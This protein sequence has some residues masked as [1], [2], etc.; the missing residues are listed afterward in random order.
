[1]QYKLSMQLISLLFFF[2]FS[3][4]PINVVAEELDNFISDILVQD[5]IK[6]I[7]IKEKPQETKKII[8]SDKLQGARLDNFLLNFADKKKKKKIIIIDPGHGGKDPGAIGY[9]KIQEKAITLLVAKKLK[10]KLDKT[11]RYK[12]FLTRNKDFFLPLRERNKIAR[13]KKADLFISIHADSALNKKARGLSLYTLSKVA[14]SDEASLLAKKE[15][16]AD[17]ISGINLTNLD[18]EI[19]DVIIDLSLSDA[20]EES[21]KFARLL[22][23]QFKKDKKIILR[24]KPIHSAG[25]VVLK[26]PNMVSLLLEIGFLS[27]RLDS[28][29]LKK[30]YYQDKIVNSLTKVI[31]KFLL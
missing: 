8:K 12:V 26:N 6:T 11:G 24:K 21:K 23:K 2:L 22:I 28:R 3:I 17:L 1:M 30:R 15:N 18:K 7:Q 9:K 14:S 27:N 20:E 5:N 10:H 4:L 25:F 29:A 19:S 31:N 16:K 13:Q